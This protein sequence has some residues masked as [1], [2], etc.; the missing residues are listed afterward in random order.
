[1]GSKSRVVQSTDRESVDSPSRMKG[2]APKTDEPQGR[3]ETGRRLCAT[4][5][6]DPNVN[7]P[8]ATRAGLARDVQRTVEV[9]I[10][11]SNG[12][13]SPI[14]P[15]GS[16][17]ADSLE[18][19]ILCIILEDRQPR[20]RPLERM[21]DIS[22]LCSSQRSSQRPIPFTDTRAN[23]SIRFLTRMAREVF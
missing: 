2:F 6:L 4:V 18:G 7:D 21:A 13:D 1:M 17:V 3:A 9:V 12:L 8:A 22:A 15:L 10:G 23:P 11:V 20:I 16:V 14:D 5:N 19:L